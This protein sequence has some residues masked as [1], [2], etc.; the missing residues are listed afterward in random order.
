MSGR[1]G[2]FFIADHRRLDELLKTAAGKGGS[3]D[4]AAYAAFRAGILRHI[5][6]EER[7]LFPAARRARGGASLSV[8]R[9]LRFDH[10]AIAALLVPPP[11]RQLIEQIVSVLGPHNEVEERADGVYAVC[12]ELLEPEAESLLL[13][14][15]AYPDVPLNPHRDGPNVRAHIAETVRIAR[16]AWEAV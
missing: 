11:D 2:S 10:G 7:I 14:L 12:D 9:L 13:Q 1:L 15:R 16:K 5:A 4:S 3:I 8:A 6:W